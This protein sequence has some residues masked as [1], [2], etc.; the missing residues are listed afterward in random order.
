MNA[1]R[2]LSTA[3]GFRWSGVQI[4][5][6]RPILRHE[7]GSGIDPGAVVLLGVSFTVTLRIRRSE[8]SRPSGRRPR[9]PRRRGMRAPH[10]LSFPSFALVTL[11]GVLAG[12]DGSLGWVR[13]MYIVSAGLVLWLTL[14]RGLTAVAARRV[15]QEPVQV[16]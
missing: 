3:M 7:N 1:C 10:A 8:D 9:L 16:G 13:L 12:S 15:A 4:A 2:V 11:H 5:P 14:Y 6:A